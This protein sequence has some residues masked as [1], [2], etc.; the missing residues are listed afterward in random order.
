MARLRAAGAIVLG[1][2]NTPGPFFWLETNNR[3]YGRT[4]NAYDPARTAGGSSGG[5]GA[6]VGSGGAPI[7]L[8]SDMG[9]SIR[10]PAFFNGDLRAPALAWPRADHRA[11]PD[12]VGRDPPHVVHRP[13]ARRART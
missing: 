10:M 6:M 3:I 11:L 5:D 12:A 8:G 9:G 7:A 4:S 1:V 13:L 2:G